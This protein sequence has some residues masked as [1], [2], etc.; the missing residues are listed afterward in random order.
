MAPGAGRGGRL[1][2]AAGASRGKDALTT[3]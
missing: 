3:G 2:R 1:E